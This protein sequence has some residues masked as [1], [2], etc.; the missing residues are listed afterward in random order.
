MKQ[1]IGNIVLRQIV[2]FKLGFHALMFLASVVYS[3]ASVQR[4]VPVEDAIWVGM[5]V[6]TP[7]CFLFFWV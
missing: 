7:L 1:K 6:L 4:F 2:A 5:V 3:L